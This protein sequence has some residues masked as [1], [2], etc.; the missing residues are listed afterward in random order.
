MYYEKIMRKCFFFQILTNRVRAK[1]IRVNLESN[2]LITRFEL[3]FLINIFSN[4]NLNSNFN[5]PNRVLI[6]LNSNL[7][8][9]KYFRLRSINIKEFYFYIYTTKKEKCSNHATRVLYCNK[10]FCKKFNVI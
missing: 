6:E 8:I 9:N 7:F 10:K 3:I 2:I 5:E 4:S 1:R